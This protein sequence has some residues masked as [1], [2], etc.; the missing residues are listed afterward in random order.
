MNKTRI[1]LVIAFSIF[2]LIGS[3]AIQY[4][5][6]SEL[7]NQNKILFEQN[8]NQALRYAVKKRRRQIST[9]SFFCSTQE[10]SKQAN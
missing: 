3:I 8:I 10:F 5:W 6:I 7:Y 2:A 9:Q 1:K 4:Y